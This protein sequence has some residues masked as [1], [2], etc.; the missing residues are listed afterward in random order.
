MTR[1]KF[2]VIEGGDGTGKSTL[3][4]YIKDHWPAAAGE[5]FLA[6]D[7]EDLSTGGLIARIAQAADFRCGTW[8]QTP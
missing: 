1:G 5:V 6:S 7:G 4:Q 8:D 2:I 3:I